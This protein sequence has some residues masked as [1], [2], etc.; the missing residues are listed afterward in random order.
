[1]RFL[2]VAIAVLFPADPWWAV[3]QSGV[4]SNLRGISVVVN[5][6]AEGDA[7]IWATGSN[8]A[9]VRS[10]DSGKSWKRL[11][12]P[13]GDSLDSRGVQAFD[14]EIAYVMASGEGAKSRIYKTT[15]GG[16][17][18]K[19][20]YRGEDK[21][22]FLDALVCADEKHCFALSDPVDGKFLLI[23]TEDGETWKELPREHMPAAL[24]KEGAFAASN[25]ALCLDGKD[26]YFGTGGPAAR[27]F[28][29][30][31]LGRIWTVEETPIASGNA[32]SGIFSLVCGG[33][34][35]VAVGGDYQNPAQSGKNAAYSGDGG[36]TWE[37]AAIPPTGYRSGVASF[38][39][40][41]VAVGP[42]GTEVSADGS[43]WRHVDST[44]LNAIAFSDGGRKGWAAGPQGSVA[45]FID[46]TK[47]LL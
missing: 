18:W 26:V 22:F 6:S 24:A 3:R 32:S 41:Y 46:R 16:R 29:S 31:D 44:P 33:K 14:L 9:L 37:L 30:S 34:T 36:K 21:A 7:S 17:N 27:M 13:E 35:I 20:Q 42:T 1:M 28:H 11:A 25:S 4:D 45:R 38:R 12:I 5:K 19:Q 8:D 43:H 15:D 40:G 39:T 47:Y 10:S 2:V 23:A